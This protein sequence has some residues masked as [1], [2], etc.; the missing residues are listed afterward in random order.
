V[1]LRFPWFRANHYSRTFAGDLLRLIS[2]SIRTSQKLL[3][4]SLTL[5]SRPAHSP[6]HNSIQSHLVVG[7]LLLGGFGFCIGGWAATTELSGAVVTSGSLVVDTNPKK[8][9]HLTGGVVSELNVREGDHVKE[10]QVLIHLDATQTLSQLMMV[11]KS[12]DELQARQTRLEA[13]RDNAPEMV[14]PGA[15]LARAS[16]ATS[17]QPFSDAAKAVNG[18]RTLFELRRSAR[19]G[20]RA[21]LQKRIVQLDDEIKGLTGQTDSKKQEID[22]IDSEL[23][24]V[25]ELF[26]KKLLPLNRVT[27]LER[28]RARLEGERS[29]LNGTI[30]QQ[31]GKIAET[32]IQILQ[33]DQD[34]RSE[35][36]KDLSDVRGKTI[37][38]VE[39]KVAAEDQY[40]RTDIRAPQSG[41]IH[42]LKV[43]T[44]NGVISPGETIM[45]I[46][47]D[48]DSLK[49]EVKITPP[50]I[51]KVRV[52][53][54]A[55][56]HFSAF[57]ARTTPEISGEINLVSADISQDQ[58]TGTS[59]YVARITLDPKGLERLSG[60]KLLP[61]MPV[62]AFIQTG[63]RTVLSYLVKPLNDQIARAFREK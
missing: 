53:Q 46:V 12:L 28:D 50:D 15:L 20:Q 49:V 5:F 47:P 37:E 4:A 35:V 32:E 36:A 8:I 17:G 44:V 54:S 34:L 60:L 48:I 43:H 23:Q 52:G 33:I 51:D 61:G 40:R 45:E 38:L 26:R 27:A 41:F 42:E 30:A 29:Q 58:R 2:S 10:G 21:Q 59:Y 7:V 56:L 57:N 19:S 63:E 9:Q 39:K 1:I 25:R 14:V 6:T 24:G 18:E 16:L 13:E 3:F 11:A 55:I 62:E 31:R 22:L